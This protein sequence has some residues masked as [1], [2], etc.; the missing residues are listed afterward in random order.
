MYWFS[1]DPRFVLYPE[2][3][4][5]SRSLARRMRSGDFEVRYNTAFEEVIAGCRGVERPGQPGTWITPALK[6]AFVDL[7]HRG[8]AHCAESWGADGLAGGLYGV[9]LGGVFFGESMFFLEPDASKVAFATLVADLGAAGFRLVDCQQETS[10]LA[11]LGATAIP[12]AS[13]L[14]EVAAAISLPV[15]FP[16]R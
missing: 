10:H 7:H 3:L 1:P 4:H 2:E 14:G 8:V 5:V 11:S 15:T 9:A 12:R 6:A 16:T 13:F